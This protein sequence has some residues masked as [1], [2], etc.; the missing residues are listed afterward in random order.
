MDLRHRKGIVPRSRD[1]ECGDLRSATFVFLEQF[2][3]ANKSSLGSKNTPP[4]SQ[5][6]GFKSE[7]G[8]QIAGGLQEGSIKGWKQ[9]LEA[10]GERAG[11]GPT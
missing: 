7:E 6:L 3:K 11:Q 1:D 8:G 4:P 9:N 10:K 2:Y 5:R